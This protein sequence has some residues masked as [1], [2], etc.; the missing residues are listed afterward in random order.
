MG[1]EGW[2]VEGPEGLIYPSVVVLNPDRSVR[3]LGE[4][5]MGDSD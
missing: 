5:E 2:G 1:G 4:V 3:E